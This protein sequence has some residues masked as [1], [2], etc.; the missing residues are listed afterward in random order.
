MPGRR[1]GGGGRLYTRS[2]RESFSSSSA[3]PVPNIGALTLNPGSSKTRTLCL[4]GPDPEAKGALDHH[5]HHH[6]DNIYRISDRNGRG[7]Q[8]SQPADA[9]PIFKE[10]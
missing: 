10:R 5:V 4:P 2:S 3:P 9:S 6:P 8:I 1:R 7:G